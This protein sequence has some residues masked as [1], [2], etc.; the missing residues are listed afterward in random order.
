[1]DGQFVLPPVVVRVGG[2]VRSHRN[3]ELQHRLVIACSTRAGRGCIEDER[4]ADRSG[5][6]SVRPVKPRSVQPGPLGVGHSG[7]RSN[8]PSDVGGATTRPSGCVTSDGGSLP[9]TTRC[10]RRPYEGEFQLFP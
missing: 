2:R 5:P 8:T 7:S 9:P 4:V 6:T 10:R 3:R 1:L